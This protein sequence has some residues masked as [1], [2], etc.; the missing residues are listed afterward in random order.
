VV[1]IPLICRR[2]DNP[3]PPGWLSGAEQNISPLTLLISPIIILGG[4]VQIWFGIS[5][6]MQKQWTSQIAGFIICAIFGLVGIPVGT[7]VNGYTL[8]VLIMVRGEDA[9]V[10]EPKRKLSWNCFIYLSV[11]CFAVGCLYL[12]DIRVDGPAVALGV[13]L[14][15]WLHIGLLVIAI[16]A[17]AIVSSSQRALL[18]CAIMIIS[19]IAGIIV[20]VGHILLR[21]PDN[22]LWPFGLILFSGCGAVVISMGVL[23]GFWAGKL[24]RNKRHTK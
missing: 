12:L 4:V 15:K 1:A 20:W 13:N 9:K 14:F 21:E 6:I 24:I 5:L 18:A 19:E 16:C 17:G 23:L 11:L 2:Q 3:R 8:W 10:T 7:V 22:N